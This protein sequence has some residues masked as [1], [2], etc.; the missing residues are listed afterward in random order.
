MNTLSQGSRTKDWKAS[1]LSLD[2]CSCGQTHALVG[3]AG[4]CGQSYQMR[5]KDLAMLKQTLSRR[6]GQ[7]RGCWRFCLR[8]SQYCGL[9]NR[10]TEPGWKADWHLDTLRIETRQ[11]GYWTIIFEVSLVLLRVWRYFKHQVEEQNLF[12]YAAKFHICPMRIGMGQSCEMKWPLP[13]QQKNSAVECVPAC[14]DKSSIR[15]G[16]L[17]RKGNKSKWHSTQIFFNS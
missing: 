8:L 2:C 1:M 11:I 3:A 5:Q 4:C 10:Q 12:W 13:R 7:A 6:Q 14:E 16:L 17:A 9:H 15:F